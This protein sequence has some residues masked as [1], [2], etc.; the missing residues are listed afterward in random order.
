MEKPTILLLDL[1]STLSANFRTV[2]GATRHRGFQHAI[3]E[4][5][6]YREWLVEWIKRSGMTCY[7]FTARKDHNRKVTMESIAR[8]LDGWMP[9]EP[10]F[11]DTGLDRPEL[12]KE[13]MLKRHILPKHPAQTIFAFESN[14]ST[15]SM[16]VGYGIRC[17]RI[18]TIDSLPTVESLENPDFGSTGADTTQPKQASLIQ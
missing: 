15:R 18:D 14:S 2:M 12:A 9:D 6:I 17:I 7:L 10:Y 8:K 13:Q 16:M 1:N 5:E 11:N 3:S 4:I